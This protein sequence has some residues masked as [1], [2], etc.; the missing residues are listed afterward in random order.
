MFPVK[1]VL[2]LLLF[3]VNHSVC[4]YFSRRDVNKGKFSCISFV[5]VSKY[6]RS[7]LQVLSGKMSFQIPITRSTN[8]FREPV[9]FSA[10][11][12]R[13]MIHALACATGTNINKKGRFNLKDTAISGHC[14]VERSGVN[15]ILHFTNLLSVC[16]KDAR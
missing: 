12:S 9:V 4:F 8:F 7:K 3:I 10:S 15:F 13:C 14:W 11:I 16:E 2:L 1:S 6:S 5:R